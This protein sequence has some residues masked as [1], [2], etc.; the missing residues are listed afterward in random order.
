[1]GE[2]DLAIKDYSAA[3][4]KWVA[5]AS[6]L[7]MLINGI[8]YKIVIIYKQINI[9]HSFFHLIIPERSA[10][11]LLHLVH[12]WFVGVLGLVCSN[13]VILIRGECANSGWLRY[14]RVIARIKA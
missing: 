5:G 4:Q 11:S 10:D 6:D 14:P 9:S 1:M 13:H 2:L 12:L 7:I 8:I 3:L